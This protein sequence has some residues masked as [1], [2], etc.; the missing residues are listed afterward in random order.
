MFCICR[1]DRVRTKKLTGSSAIQA[2]FVACELPCGASWLR[3][4][5]VEHSRTSVSWACFSWAGQILHSRILAS[6]LEALDLTA[7][8]L[9]AK[10]GE[11]G[12]RSQHSAFIVCTVIYLS[13]FSHDTFN[14]PAHTLLSCTLRSVKSLH[15]GQMGKSWLPVVQSGES[16]LEISV[17]GAFTEAFSHPL[18]VPVSRGTGCCWFLG[19]VKVLECEMS[20]SLALSTAASSRPVNPSSLTHPPPS[21][22]HFLAVVSSS[23]PS[24]LV[25]MSVKHLFTIVLVCFGREQVRCIYTLA[26]KSG[27]LEC[28]CFFFFFLAKI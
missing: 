1:H 17:S 13:W 15:S 19:F 18:C 22:C 9:G 3:G 26:S 2:G 16:N 21:F 28:C 20:S 8:V 4:P 10:L 23:V 11:E 14:F 25:D 27:S 6:C 24:V 12:G 5:F 7:R